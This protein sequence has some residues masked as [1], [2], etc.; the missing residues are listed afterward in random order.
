MVFECSQCGECCSIMGRMHAIKEERSDGE[1]LLR[2]QYTGEEQVVRI[3]P[4]KTDL[5]ADRSIFADWPDACPFLRRDPR[6]EKAYCTVHRTRPDICREFGC[7]TLLI[8]DPQGRRVGR[9]M[10]RRHLCSEDPAFFTVWQACVG[11]IQ[12]ADDAAWRERV[13]SVLEAAG[14]HVRR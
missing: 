9:V 5:Y 1:F 7:W 3:D 11:G 4:E 10:G 8:L 6:D 13:A 12:E 2:N 14:Y